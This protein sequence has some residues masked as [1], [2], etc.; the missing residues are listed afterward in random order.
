MSFLSRHTFEVMILAAVVVAHSFLARKLWP[1]ASPDAVRK[2][3]FLVWGV[4]VF[5]V[6]GISLDSITVARLFPTPFTIWVRMLGVWYQM[7]SAGLIAIW[8]VDNALTRRFRRFRPDTAAKSNLPRRALLTAARTSVYALP[9]V[10]VGYG[11]FIEKN[12]LDLVETDLYLPDLP[13][14]LDGLRIVQITDVHMGMFLSPREFERVVGMANETKA[15]FA[16]MTGDLVTAM[17]DPVDDCISGLARIESEAG[18]FGCLGNHEIYAEAEDYVEQAAARSGIR[19]LRNKSLQV[20][21]RG[22]TLNLAGVDYQRK[23]RP[24]LK[25]AE[26]LVHPE[27]AVNLLLSH[28]PDVFPVAAA[29]GFDAILSGHTHGGQVTVEFLQQYVNPARFFTPYVAGSYY[30]DKSAIYVSR[31]VGT[32]GVPTRIFAPPEVTLVRLRTGSRPQQAVARRSL[33]RSK[34]TYRET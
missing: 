12:R 9:M 31:G 33:F 27:A 22:H 28:N 32:V 13:S 3:R 10:A 25:G 11:T 15:H 5:L 21:F 17:G 19:F 23:S 14:E 4:A 7:L 26:K 18:M 8:L 34:Q 16:V 1:G 6:F 30:L 2:R 29:K 20:K 24:Y